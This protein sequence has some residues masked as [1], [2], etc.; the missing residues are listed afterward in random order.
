M[1]SSQHSIPFS[2]RN[3]KAKLIG[4]MTVCITTN[5]S[6]QQWPIGPYWR[7]YDMKCLP[8]RVVWLVWKSTCHN[9]TRTLQYNICLNFL[10]AV[11][12]SN[13]NRSISESQIMCSIQTA[14]N[15][16]RSFVDDMNSLFV[17]QTKYAKHN[18]VLKII[19]AKRYALISNSP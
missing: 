15:P 7:I 10:I 8:N 12:K 1:P 6:R 16:I 2:R 14:I 9:K 3:N 13:I 5:R 17:F 18:L 4:L 19:D 11:R